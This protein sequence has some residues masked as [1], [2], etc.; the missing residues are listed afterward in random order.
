[1]LEL[2]KPIKNIYT[3]TSQQCI[4]S[5]STTSSTLQFTVKHIDMEDS[6][7]KA[8]EPFS[9]LKEDC[10]LLDYWEKISTESEQFDNARKRRISTPSV[11]TISNSKSTMSNNRRARVVNE[12]SL[13]P[14]MG[15][16]RGRLNE[17]YVHYPELPTAKQPCC[18][19]CRF[20]TENKNVRTYT[21][22]FQ[23]DLCKVH[24]CITCFKPFHTVSSV[25]NLKS[26]V[27]SCLKDK[28]T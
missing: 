23:C 24:L 7:E 1:V 28:A 21:S 4:P 25:K 20:V 9:V 8:I 12:A 22:M 13:D 26:Q 10:S 3:S 15:A 16:L 5:T 19:L 14:T 6:K 27:L 17:N 18:S 2:S 11:S